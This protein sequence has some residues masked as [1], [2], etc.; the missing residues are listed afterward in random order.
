MVSTI[1]GRAMILFFQAEDGIRDGRVTGVQTCALPIL[2]DAM[3][4]AGI[5]ARYDS[6]SSAVLAVKAGADMILKTP[7]VD[8][9]IAALKQAVVRCEIMESRINTSVKR[10]LQAK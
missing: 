6:A 7:D 1:V 9:A 5:A 2:T 3:E 10:I 4:M 8:A